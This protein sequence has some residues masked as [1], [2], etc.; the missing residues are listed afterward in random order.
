ML[1]RFLNFS[2]LIKLDMGAESSKL[3][4]KLHGSPLLLNEF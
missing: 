1:F 4:E 2:I 3:F